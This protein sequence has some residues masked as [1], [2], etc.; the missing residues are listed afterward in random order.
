MNKERQ[1]QQ[2]GSGSNQAIN[3]RAINQQWQAISRDRNRNQQVAAKPA[4]PQQQRG[5]TNTGSKAQQQGRQSKQAAAKAT[6]KPWQTRQEGQNQ[7]QPGLI[8]RGDKK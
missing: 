6:T 7:N 8:I 4:R 5:T 3:S 1:Q 2:Q